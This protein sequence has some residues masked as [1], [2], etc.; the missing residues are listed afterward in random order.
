MARPDQPI[1][2][3]AERALR[4]LRE[5][6]HAASSL[7]MARS[8][9][10][11]GAPDEPSA[12]SVLEAA[13]SGDPRLAYEGGKWRIAEP[14]PE[15]RSPRSSAREP[16][17]GP[18]PEPLP[19]VDDPDRVLLF[20]EGVPRTS[21][22]PFLL[23]T[24]SALRLQGD[25]VVAA[26]GGD[27]TQ[28]AASNRLRRAV[29]K[30]LEGAVPVIHDPPGAI[31][32]LE[33]WLGEPLS[34]AISLRRLGQERLGLAGR[35]DLPTLVARL[36]LLWRSTDDPL[37]LADTLDAC[38]VRLR[39]PG[40]ALRGLQ[41]DRS[42]A[43]AIDWSRFA[44]GREL[45]DELPH[46]PGTYRF[47]DRNG[48][49][50]YVGK[51]RNLSRRVGS[52]FR[53]TPGKRAA[54]EQKLLDELYRIEYEP[55]GSDLE[56][57]LREAEEIKTKNPSGN[58]QREVHVRRGRTA[59]L[60]SILI[61]EPAEPPHVLRAY[62]IRDGRLVGRAR[63]GPRGGGLGHVQRVLEDRFFS[64]PTGPTPTPGADLDVEIVARWLAAHRDR[65]V[66]FDPTDLRTADEVIERL[67]W[68]LTQGSP[69]DP[70]GAPV[71]VRG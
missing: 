53:V 35:H 38:L 16:A 42:G 58:V 29:L 49:L 69:F 37:E 47:Y 62:M 41:R 13:F 63:L 24:V 50:L 8:V 67:R 57:M 3:A 54:R 46:V 7:E 66:A 32:A 12:T 70:D 14:T 48:G 26:C 11:L 61:L 21:S 51:A 31:A 20:V 19:R 55:T 71:H 6:G 36:G 60:M 22:A 4:W 45:L 65:V 30:T 23:Q 68:F 34:N 25:E 27:A 43:A 18:E 10:A 56:A 1:S 9:L 44:F 5:R 52:Y 64:L 15:A 39:Q 59:R 2:L 40:E 17:P 28:G 33:R